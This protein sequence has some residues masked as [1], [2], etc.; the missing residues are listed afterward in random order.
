MAKGYVVRKAKASQIKKKVDP[1]VDKI[2]EN[3][4]GDIEEQK[5]VETKELVTVRI[6]SDNSPRGNM[7]IDINLN[8]RNYRIYRDMTCKI[9]KEIAEILKRSS[10]Y[11]TENSDLRKTQLDES[12]FYVSGRVKKKES[13]F[14]LIEF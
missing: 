2:L 13:R 14:N 12:G 3:Q 7:P 11:I 10:K 8:G 1:K 6:P 5:L 4:G 9:P